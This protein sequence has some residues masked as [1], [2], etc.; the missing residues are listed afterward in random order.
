MNFH[1]EKKSVILGL[2]I[3]V[4]AL[5]A[6]NV[7]RFQILGNIFNIHY[8]LHLHCIHINGEAIQREKETRHATQTP[9]HSMAVAIKIVVKIVVTGK[10]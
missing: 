5:L 10:C 7:F 4:I 9:L 6:R 3:A 2:K 1:K 8:S